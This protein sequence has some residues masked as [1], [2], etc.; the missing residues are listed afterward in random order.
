MAS[1]LIKIY[2]VKEEK[3]YFHQSQGELEVLKQNQKRQTFPHAAM[4][5]VAKCH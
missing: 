4:F 3:Y 1:L 5:E 2:F